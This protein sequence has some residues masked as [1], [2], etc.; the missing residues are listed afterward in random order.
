MSIF[1]LN[2]LKKLIKE[3]KKQVLREALEEY[4]KP[5]GT[6]DL[7][8][9]SKVD[10]DAVTLD[11][12]YFLH[13]RNP[14]SKNEW[15]KAATPRLFFYLD[16]KEKERYFA[17][18]PLYKAAVPASQIYDLN[19]DQEGVVQRVREGGIYPGIF[20]YEELLNEL[21]GWEQV[22]KNWEKT[23]K[24]LHPGVYYKNS[25]FSVMI[26]FEP[27]EVIRVTEEEKQELEKE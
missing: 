16:P 10:H 17:S 2:E 21:S 5:D 13:S 24:G 26:Y 3:V 15:G 7:Y 20:N 12:E 25:Q 9:Y 11:P 6:V 14:Y 8:H 4:V 19:K 1:S 27:I 23:S 22:G 18:M